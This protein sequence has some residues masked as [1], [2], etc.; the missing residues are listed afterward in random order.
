MIKNNLGKNDK[1]IVDGGTDPNDQSRFCLGQIMN[2][3]RSNIIKKCR[4]HIGN[5]IELI[6]DSESSTGFNNFTVMTCALL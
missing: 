6:R 3:E 2:H 4:N 1:I 5:G